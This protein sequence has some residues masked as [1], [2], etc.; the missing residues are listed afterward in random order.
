[1]LAFNVDDYRDP[2]FLNYFANEHIFE[3]KFLEITVN[4]LIANS[5]IFKLDD[6]Y[7]Y[8]PDKVAYQ[9]YGDDLYYPWILQANSMGSIFNFIPSEMDYE[10]FIPNK[11]FIDKFKK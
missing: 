7:K 5:D 1:M 9:V 11:S 10:C 3:N 6:S 4:D 8:S 2:F